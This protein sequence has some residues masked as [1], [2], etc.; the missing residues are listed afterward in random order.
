[1]EQELL[2]RLG[3]ITEEERALL[4]GSGEIDKARYTASREFTVDSRKMLEKGRLI[5][6]RTH[7]RFA[8]FPEHRHNYIEIMYM[9]S[10]QTL[11]CIGGREVTVKKGELLFLNQRCAHEIYP[12]GE[13]DI[14]IN[15]II[16]PEFF[17]VA[18]SM[19]RRDTILGDFVIE[20]LRGAPGAPEYLHFRVENV[21]P[22]Q[23]LVENMVW[24]LVYRQEDGQRLSQITMGL[25]FLQLL[26]YTDSIER[27][28]RN[29]Y[30][31]SLVMGALKYIEE[32]CRSARLEE[33]AGSRRQ[34]LY[35]MS[36]LIR[37]NTGSTFKELL[38]RQRLERAKELLRA[39]SLSAED[40]IR[41]VGYDNT[42]YFYRLFRRH[43]GMSPR[44]YR[45]EEAASLS[46]GEKTAPEGPEQPG[47][48]EREKCK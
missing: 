39:T 44:Q 19:L 8:R 22:V 41:A 1:M 40:I 35:Y 21:L 48:G 12:A 3:T 38:Q 42:S 47:A 23:N 6:V 9:C 13:Q 32:N 15:F 43:T 16:L 2:K 33:Y 25:L 27:S 5:D 34:P 24:A 30:E 46:A 11:H 20:C 10:G 31:N 37:K 14:G 4:L 45:D 18:L 28:D 29:Q 17:D 26:E 7:T 36:R